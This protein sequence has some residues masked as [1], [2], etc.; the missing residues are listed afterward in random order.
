MNFTV[1]LFQKEFKI[2]SGFDWIKIVQRRVLKCLDLYAKHVLIII[3]AYSFP[4]IYI[5]R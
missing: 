2:I 4:T 3:A 5:Q 1:Y